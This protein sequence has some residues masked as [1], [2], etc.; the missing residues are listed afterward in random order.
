MGKKKNA[1][2]YV[3]VA[4]PQG[5]GPLRRARLRWKDNIKMYLKGNGVASCGMDSSGSGFG[6][7]AV[8]S[9]AINL[10]VL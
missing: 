4:N 1:C 3:L 5:K 2:I 9:I 8:V 6:E 10:R 7:V